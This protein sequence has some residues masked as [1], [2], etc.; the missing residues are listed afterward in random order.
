MLLPYSFV[1]FRSYLLSFL[2]YS[3]L[4]FI[5]VFSLSFYRHFVT[6]FVSSA[7]CT[8]GFIKIAILVTSYVT[9]KTVTCAILAVRLVIHYESSKQ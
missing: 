2:N 1:L 9:N 6:S 5:F 8:C 3:V 7:S 4:F